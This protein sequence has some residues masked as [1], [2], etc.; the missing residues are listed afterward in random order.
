VVDSKGM[1]YNPLSKIYR[2]DDNTDVNYQIA[3]RPQ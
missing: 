1:T 2:L 3:C